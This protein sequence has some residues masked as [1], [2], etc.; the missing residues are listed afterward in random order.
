MSS[1][2]FETNTPEVENLSLD[3]T[4]SMIEPIGKRWLEKSMFPDSMYGDY[5]PEITLEQ[6]CLVKALNDSRCIRQ[7]PDGRLYL[8]TLANVTK[9]NETRITNH[10]SINH[11]VNDNPGGYWG[12]S[13]VIVIMPGKNAFE[14]NGVPENITHFD[15][16]WS[17]DTQIPEGSVIIWRG[18]KPE[19]YMEHD[20]YI[21]IELNL[22]EEN[23]EIKER[24]AGLERLIHEP[25]ISSKDL[26][27][28]MFILHE[29]KKYAHDQLDNIVKS[30]VEKMGYTYLPYENG[31]YSHHNNLESQL[32]DLG[33]KYGIRTFVPH[34]D[35]YSGLMETVGFFD[36]GA[37]TVI[38]RMNKNPT[39]E[40]DL[41]EVLA[42]YSIIARDMAC[43]GKNPKPT[44]SEISTYFENLLDGDKNIRQIF[45][46]EL[47]YW[48]NNN[49]E[50]AGNNKKIREQLKL[51]FDMDPY[52]E[53]LILQ[54]STK[55]PELNKH[56]N[57]L[58]NSKKHPTKLA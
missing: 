7:S 54:F 53:E 35:T 37:L 13:E 25:N 3:S 41:G 5:S 32:I 23:E 8:P 18:K 49:I 45:A 43:T 21:N 24:I 29:L 52:L 36:L 27:T 10:T 34:S 12:T 57:N 44:K 26:N 50:K 2:S 46:S 22:G 33:E 14:L 1:D 30:V 58:N 11:L 28:N 20:G 51:L 39:P 17:G 48:L 4:L 6:I 40:D 56:L 19:D 38:S 9:G 31:R 42:S 47:F 55:S 15:T 16:F